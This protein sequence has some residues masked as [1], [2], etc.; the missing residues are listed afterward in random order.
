MMKQEKV[1]VQPKMMI[2]KELFPHH[3]AQLQVLILPPQ[4]LPAKELVLLQEDLLNSSNL[5]QSSQNAMVATVSLVLTVS[6]YMDSQKSCRNQ[7]TLEDSFNCQHAIN[8]SLPTAN[9][10]VTEI[11]PLDVLKE[12]PQK[13]QEETDSRANGLISLSK[14]PSKLECYQETVHPTLCQTHTVLLLLLRLLPSENSKF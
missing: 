7:S 4:V 2:P 10:S 11:S 14:P 3:S 9:Q 1:P 13:D 12:E 6:Q 8:G 5:L